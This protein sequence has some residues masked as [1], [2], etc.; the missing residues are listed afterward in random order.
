M[1]HETFNADFYVTAA[2]VIPVLY[3]ALTLQGPTFKRLLERGQDESFKVLM[4]ELNKGSGP[5][6]QRQ[7]EM[8]G[9]SFLSVGFIMAN[10]GI[11]VAGFLGEPIAIVALYHK[12]AS[13]LSAQVVLGTML[14]LLAVVA[15]G[16]V[17]ILATAPTLTDRLKKAGEKSSDET[18]NHHDGG[19][20]PDV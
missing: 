7:T 16:Q 18:F 15:G 5:W 20:D 1:H 19:S 9:R 4:L 13:H 3:L 8:W 11:L 10:A 17:F 14:A 12:S 2:T 6:L